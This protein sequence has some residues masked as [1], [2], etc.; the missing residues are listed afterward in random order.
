MSRRDL[1]PADIFDDDEVM[2]DAEEEPITAA[3]RMAG[4]STGG[5]SMH[6]TKVMPV[7]PTYGLPETH[8]TVIPANLFFTIVRKGYTTPTTVDIDMTSPYTWHP[9]FTADSGTVAN[10][11][12]TKMFVPGA[13]GTATN[14]LDYPLAL[15]STTQVVPSWRTYFE[16]LYE[17]YH[18]M[19]CHWELQCVRPNVA[20]V[21]SDNVQSADMM[22]VWGYQSHK[23]GESSGNIIPEG[24]LVETLSWKHVNHQMIKGCPTDKPNEVTTF[25]GSYKSGQVRHNVRNDEDV[26]TWT[27]VSSS[28]SLVEQL[29]LMFYTAPMTPLVATANDIHFAINCQLRIKWIVQYKDLKVAG[30]YPNT[31]ATTI[32]Q[33]LP[34]DALQTIA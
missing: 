8:T 10:G 31:G 1:R 29:R 26:Q 14:S 3:A 20:I 17:K 12:F 7:A 21:A 11:K 9:L 13:T 23:T 6:E 16:D 18:V 32:T 5:K 19:G 24:T 33:S 25:S 28:P 22:C 27:N 4:G 34:S 30:R 2:T 15:T